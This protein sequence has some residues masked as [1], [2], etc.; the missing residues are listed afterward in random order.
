MNNTDLINQINQMN[1]QNAIN[2]SLYYATEECASRPMTEAET[3]AFMGLIGF[4][5]LILIGVI[6]WSSIVE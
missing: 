6:I 4:L 2:T 3:M 1:M 5:V